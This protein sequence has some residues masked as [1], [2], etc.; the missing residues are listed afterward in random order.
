MF[1]HS[2]LYFSHLPPPRVRHVHSWK[3]VR[4]Q[5][6]RT[7]HPE[8][9]YTSPDPDQRELISWDDLDDMLLNPEDGN[10]NANAIYTEKGFLLPHRLPKFSKDTPAHG[11]LM[12]LKCVDDLF[13]PPCEQLGH[14]S[15]ADTIDTYTYLQ[16]GL[17]VAGHFQANGLMMNFLPFLDDVNRDLNSL[18]ADDDDNDVDCSPPPSHKVVHGLG[19]QGYNAVMHLTRGDSA[20]HHDAQMGMITGALA[21]SWAKDAAAE[22]TARNLRER[23]SRQLPHASF[24]EKIQ[25]VNI[26]RDLRLENV[27]YINVNAINPHFQDG[28]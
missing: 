10:A 15:P 24:A 11:I 16:A 9:V 28:E 2:I 12:N 6:I 26:S 25:N 14:H 13:Q 5:Q 23:C 27:Y 19:C 17:K 4:P 20:Q 8:G 7:L 1:L 3:S 18:E 22:K 21:G